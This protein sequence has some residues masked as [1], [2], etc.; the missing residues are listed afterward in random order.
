MSTGTVLSPIGPRADRAGEE[1]NESIGYTE[2]EGARIGQSTLA[3][4]TKG[5]M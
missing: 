3:R 5:G 2:P 4:L 1:A